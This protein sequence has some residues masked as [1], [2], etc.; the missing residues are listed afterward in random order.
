MNLSDSDKTYGLFES[1]INRKLLAELKA[2]KSAIYK[3]PQV[4]T[5]K[6]PINKKSAEY[7]QN[8]TSF[9]CVIF[10]DVLAVGYF[11][12]ILE[13]NR[14]ELYDLDEVRILT[15]G[16]AVSDE[17]RLSQIHADII[18][19]SLNAPTVISSLKNY[20]GANDFQN[21]KI[22]IVREKNNKPEISDLLSGENLQITQMPV[23][24]IASSRAE[25]TKLK[26]ILQSGGIDEFIITSPI[27]LISLGYFFEKMS[28]DRIFRETKIFA[29][30]DL[31][32]KLLAENDI[33][34]Q[35]W[36]GKTGKM[37]N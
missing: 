31:I 7:I 9:D 18:P 13:E 4:K 26:I 33:K 15:Y 36:S 35:L 34:H 5:K 27:D 25:L 1:A 12:E 37:E 23:Y 21:L 14:I 16:E 22:L 32:S 28:L 24:E 11:L 20:F 2:G 19:T 10:T 8:I 30:D 3:F 17:L 29:K 6:I